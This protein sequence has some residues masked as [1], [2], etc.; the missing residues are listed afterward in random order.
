MNL[1]RHGPLASAPD[2]GCVVLPKG[3]PVAHLA[4]EM[5]R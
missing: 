5:F 4:A 3:R 2:N 1:R